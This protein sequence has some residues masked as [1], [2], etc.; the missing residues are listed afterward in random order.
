M[1]CKKLRHVL[2]DLFLSLLITKRGKNNKCWLSCQSVPAGTDGTLRVGNEESFPW[3]DYSQWR[4]GEGHPQGR[5]GPGLQPTDSGYHRR[6]AGGCECTPGVL[7]R[8][9][10]RGAV[11][12]GQGRPRAQC[13]RQEQSFRLHTKTFLSSPPAHHPPLLPTGWT[14]LA[15]RGS[16]NGT[17]WGGWRA[18]WESKW[19]K[20][21]PNPHISHVASHLI[22][23]AGSSICTVLCH[24]SLFGLQPALG[25]SQGPG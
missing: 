18:T 15:A 16:I 21:S 25:L 6:P 7:W 2:R 20:F 1:A 12:L 14:W 17:E 23:P 22:L 8:G 3:R 5:A 9:R 11:A 13:D 4:Q 19:K 24:H 10:L